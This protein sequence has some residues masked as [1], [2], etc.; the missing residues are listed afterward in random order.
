MV[1]DD[2][3]LVYLTTIA[4]VAIG[5]SLVD[6]DEPEE[7]F[8]KFAASIAEKQRN[9]SFDG[10]K[11]FGLGGAYTAYVDLA[12]FLK[13]KKGDMYFPSVGFWLASNLKGTRPNDDE[14]LTGTSIAM[15]FGASLASWWNQD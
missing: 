10:Y 12:N 2:R 3:L 1:D 5:V 4:G 9:W 7:E 11:P 13:D 14:V 6:D 15:L 8:E